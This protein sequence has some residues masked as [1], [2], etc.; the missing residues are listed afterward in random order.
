VLFI[1]LGSS[2]GMADVLKACLY[3]SYAMLAGCLNIL[4][5]IPV[6]YKLLPIGGWVLLEKVVFYLLCIYL[7]VIFG[8]IGE[9]THKLPRW[10]AIL[11]ATVPFVLLVLFNIVFSHKVLPKL[12]GI[13]S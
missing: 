7:F 8:I 9:K 1:L 2:G 5:M 13:L 10:R 4:L 3:T 12:A 6:K 11:A